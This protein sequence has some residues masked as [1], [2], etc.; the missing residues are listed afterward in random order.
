MSGAVVE[1][2]LYLHEY[3]DIVG[4]GAMRY[5]DHTVSF[6]TETAAG[7][8]L[9]LL[10]TFYVMGSTGRWPQVVNIWECIQGRDRVA[11]PH[12]DHQPEP[13]EEP[14]AERLVEDRPRGALGWVRPPA[15]GRAGVPV[16][17]RPAARR[18]DRL[19]V[20]PRAL[21]VQAGRGVDYLEAVHPD[22][23]PVL[24]DYGH[25]LVG[26]YEVM[27]TDVEVMTVW[28]TDPEGHEALGRA[29]D[30]GD[31]PAHRA[32]AHAGPRVPHPLARGAHDAVPRHVA[33]PG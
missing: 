18:G 32:L 11:A 24:A 8:G 26:L 28:A 6:N 10:G 7:K 23:L 15:G 29:I 33:L 4:E 19:G 16:D 12:G 31:G 9:D 30:A 20:R 25:T 21:G 17:R 2:N 13:D 22:W 14:R 1:R 27:M 5:M 3:V